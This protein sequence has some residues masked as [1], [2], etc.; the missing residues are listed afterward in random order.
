MTKTRTVV[1]K[2]VEDSA[3]RNALSKSYGSWSRVKPPSKGLSRQL[4]GTLYGFVR[5]VCGAVM[6]S[7]GTRPVVHRRDEF[8]KFARIILAKVED[9]DIS[10]LIDECANGIFRQFP[11]AITV[12]GDELR[13][14]GNW[15][16]EARTASCY[17]RSGFPTIF[18]SQE[19]SLSCS[20]KTAEPMVE[21]KHST[22]R[23]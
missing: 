18:I 19:P 14:E 6:I 4:E 15:S 5:D 1:E 13:R 20:M 7:P 17:S 21:A 10:I 2:V 3:V 16:R 11:R 8:K 9:S 23:K 22:E 12:H